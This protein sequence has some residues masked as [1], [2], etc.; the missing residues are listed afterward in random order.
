MAIS[1]ILDARSDLG[2]FERI[3]LALELAT[4]LRNLN[5]RLLKSS[6]DSRDIVSRSNKE[7]LV[8]KISSIYRFLSIAFKVL[9]LALV[10][11]SVLKCLVTR[12]AT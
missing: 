9:S 4:H 5:P 11:F 7:L 1:L 3:D 6:V 8:N 12:S 10:G 2:I